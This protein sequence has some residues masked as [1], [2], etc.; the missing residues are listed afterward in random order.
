MSI[1]G[2]K[3]IKSRFEERIE[4][5]HGANVYCYIQGKTMIYDKW[6]LDQV[7]KSAFID[8]KN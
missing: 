1:F 3:E 6:V 8:A 7:L 5:N 4:F 2:N